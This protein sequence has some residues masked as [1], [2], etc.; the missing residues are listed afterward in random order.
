MGL[1]YLVSL[2]IASYMQLLL[3]RKEYKNIKLL[4]PKGV[5]L[6]I[7]WRIEWLVSDG[8]NERNGFRKRIVNVE[9]K[10]IQSLLIKGYSITTVH[11]SI[12]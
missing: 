9:I 10:T 5:I 1:Q 6:S 8:Y 11:L 12:L 2:S 3:W 7:T 4:M